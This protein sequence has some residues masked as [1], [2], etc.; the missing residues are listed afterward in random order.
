MEC[1]K[2]CLQNQFSAALHKHASYWNKFGNIFVGWIGDGLI[3]FD[4]NWGFGFWLAS[5]F[6]KSFICLG[7]W[8]TSSANCFL[9]HENFCFH[10][11]SIGNAK[12]QPYQ[13]L[14][15]LAA[16]KW[17]KSPR[18]FSQNMLYKRVLKVRFHGPK[19]YDLNPLCELNHDP[20]IT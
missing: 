5:G 14:K 9:I 3:Y 16:E 12:K 15:I 20:K 10:N 4:L 18:L 8:K 7:P 17:P 13:I 2:G 6:F 11:H 1:K 19:H